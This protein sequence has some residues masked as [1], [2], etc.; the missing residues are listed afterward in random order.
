[1]K[2]NDRILLGIYLH[3]RATNEDTP[4]SADEL[5]WLFKNDPKK[6]KEGDKFQKTVEGQRLDSVG[7]VEREL[8]LLKAKN[9]L[10][11]ERPKALEKNFKITILPMGICRA[12]Q[13]STILGCVDL[14]YRDNKSG[15]FGVVLTI[16]IS[17]TTSLVV[18][19]LSD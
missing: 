9:C 18:S 17:A 8:S 6:W 7:V 16:L 3:V 10:D 5:L 13:L 15:I 1:M 4:L 19:L 11:F 2:K 12:Q 14:F